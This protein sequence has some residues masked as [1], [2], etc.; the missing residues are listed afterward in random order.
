[1]ILDDRSGSIDA[2]LAIPSVPSWVVIGPDNR[3]VE[4]RTGLVTI[5]EFEA[6][7]ALASGL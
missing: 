5:E 4:R 6:L 1:V 2:A 7:V 3:V